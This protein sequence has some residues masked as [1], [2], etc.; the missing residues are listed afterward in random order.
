F[1]P[2]ESTQIISLSFSPNGREL[3]YAGV[4]RAGKS[5][6]VDV[7]SGK[8][9]L[10]FTAHSNTVMDGNFSK[11]AKL[12]VTTGGDSHETYVWNTADGTIVQKIE[13]GGKGFASAKNEW[14]PSISRRR[15]S[16]LLR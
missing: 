7:A 13:S 8:R 9:R 1:A 16:A 4:D 5:G 2:G 15:S 6:L 10:A 11:G 14:P 3:L 12:A